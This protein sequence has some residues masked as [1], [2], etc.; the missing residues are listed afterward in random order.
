MARCG[1]V[2]RPASREPQWTEFEV[3]GQL[4][5]TKIDLPAPSNA[6]SRDLAIQLERF[7]LGAASPPNNDARMISAMPIEIA[8]SATL[9]TG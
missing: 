4:G 7:G 8:L 2:W 5:R 6:S 9:N 3:A 1:G